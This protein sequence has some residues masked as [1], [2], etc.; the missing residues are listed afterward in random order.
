MDIYDVFCKKIGYR[1]LSKREK[2]L[3]SILILL[4]IEFLFYNFLL[5]DQVQST[6]EANLKENLSPIEEEFTYKGFDDFSQEKLEK[7]SSESNI[8]K[9]SF[10]KDSQSD[11]ESLIISGRVRSLDLNS[12]EG[13]TNYYGYSNIDILRSDEGNFAYRLK[14]EKPSKAIYYNNLKKAYFGE[15]NLKEEVRTEEEKKVAS[16]G[17]KAEKITNTKKNIKIENKKQTKAS[18][19]TNNKGKAQIKG[20]EEKIINL[21]KNNFAIS[22]S[23]LSNEKKSESKFDFAFNKE[24]EG[25]KFVESDDIKLD[26]YPED[27]VTSVYVRK[28]DLKD[29]VKLGVDRHCNGISLSIFLPNKSF[30]EMGTIN[31]A[32]NY[33]PYRGEILENNWTRIDLYQDDM[34]Y[35]YFTPEDDKDLLIFIKEVDYH[36]EERSLYPNWACNLHRNNFTP[37]KHCWT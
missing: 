18:K 9:D 35:I 15:N 28:K 5:N 32:G 22:H 25:L 6:S 36:E 2:I 10:S 3:F 21:N 29:L 37:L 33:S 11:I 20:Q 30:K 31:I 26:Y 13:L 7:I 1:K 27:K 19:K 14:A 8:S 17:P 24:D 12:I 34:S 16:Q 23:I 4:V